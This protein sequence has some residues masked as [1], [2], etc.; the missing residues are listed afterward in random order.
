MSAVLMWVLNVAWKAAAVILAWCLL[1]HLLR[2]GSGALLETLEVLDLS[3]KTLCVIVKN[4]LALCLLKQKKKG[5]EPLLEEEN[6][7]EVKVIGSIR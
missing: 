4:K 5:E 7:E 6:D 1:R 3:F 2:H